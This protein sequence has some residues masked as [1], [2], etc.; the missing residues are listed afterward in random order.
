MKDAVPIPVWVGSGV[1]P[2]NLMRYRVAD[3]FIVGSAIKKGGHWSSPVDPVKR[4]ALQHDLWAAF[5][6][7]AWYPDDWVF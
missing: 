5:D 6:Y 7:A 2:E 4:F 1:T 3:G